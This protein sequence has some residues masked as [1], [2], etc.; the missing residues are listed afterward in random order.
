MDIKSIH[1]EFKPLHEKIIGNGDKAF[2]LWLEFEATSPWDDIEN[3]FANIC[4]DTL[5]GR[6][7]GINVWTFKFL[8]TAWKEKEKGS[9]STYII[10]PDLFV[11]ELTRDCIEETIRELLN[12]GNLEETLNK[13]IFELHFLKPYQD[14]MDMDEKN[15]HSL[16]HE[17]KLELSDHHLLNKESFE[18]IAR[19]WHNDEI[20]LE[21]ENGK[22]AV[23]HLTWKASKEVDGYPITRIYSN[24]LD[25]WNQEMKQNI[26]EFN[27]EALKNGHKR[28]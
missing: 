10:P 19:K 1:K 14:A 15:I 24:E 26:L 11:K 5:D 22:I 16:I 2:R 13:S 3:N 7:Y 18:L 17:L 21:L 28:T 6:R 9:N 4:V 25:F 20:I 27:L 8:S 12:H 23:V